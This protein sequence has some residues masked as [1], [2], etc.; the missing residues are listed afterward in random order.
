MI[1]ITNPDQF[2]QL[3]S[4][5]KTSEKMDNN[6]SLKH[7]NILI[8]GVSRASG[9]GAAIAKICVQ[10][11]ANVVIHGNPQYDANRSYADASLDFCF[12]LAREYNL[13]T[14]SPSDLSA[15]DEPKKARG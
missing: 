8:T 5:K 12:D 6:L 14:I 10:A 9:I 13:K 2:A 15:P 3:I 7:K 4:H 1:S 11:G